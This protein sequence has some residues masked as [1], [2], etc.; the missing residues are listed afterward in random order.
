MKNLLLVFLFTSISQLVYAQTFS[1]KGQVKNQQN[2]VVSFATIAV[3]VSKDSSLAKADIADE[4]GSFKISNLKAGKYFI[5]ITAVSFNPFSSPAFEVVDKDLEFQPFTVLADTKQLNEVKVVAAKPLIEVQND[6]I[7]FNVEGSVN[8]TGLTALEL[9]QKSPGVQVD[10]DENI[11]V[12]GKSGVRIFIDGRPSPMSGK[13]LAST[14]KSMNSADIE[15]IEVITNPSAKYDAAGDLG[16]INIRLKKNKKI[17]TNGNVALGSNFGITPKFNGSL[18]LNHRDKK[19]NVYGNYS[20][21]QGAWHNRTLDDQILNN[22]AYN[23]TW[24]GIWRDT[25]HN[26]KIGMDYFIN[27]KHTIGISANGRASDH[28]GGGES[29]TLIGNRNLARPDSAILNSRTSNPEQNKNLNI[30]LNYRFAD[31]T[32]RELNIDADYG[33]FTSRGISYQPNTYEF[34]NSDRPSF[35]RNFV[36]KTPIDISIKS[37]KIDYEQPLKKGKLGYGIKLSDVKSDN[38]FDFF[39]VLNDIEVR[40]IERSNNFVYTERVYAA[41]ANYNV[42]LNKKWDLQLGLRAER[43]HSLGQLTS[44]KQNDLDK[45]DTT[46]INLF[47]SGAISYKLSENHNLNL[48]YSRRINRPSYQNL[49]P[50]EYRIDE[51]VYSKGNPFLRPEYANNFKLTHVYKGKLTTSLGYWRTRF[52]VVGLRMP[53]DESRTYFIAQNLD[54]TQ[55][56]SLDVSLA[57]DI[58]KWWNIYVNVSGYTNVFRGDLENG[59]KINNSTIA[60][61]ANAQT[62]FKLKN[63][64]TIELSGWYNSPYRRIDYNTAMGT[65]DAGVQKKFWKDN[66]TLKV[67]FT[68][69]L[70]TGRGGHYSE[71][72]GIATN[73]R[74]QWE[75]QQL[76]VNFTY[77]FGSNEIKGARNRSSGSEDE[78]SRIKGG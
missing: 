69:V 43:T 68:D 66:A 53:Y 3:H 23:K 22:I 55:G 42:S 48:N 31:T 19:I 27:S 36:T 74:F 75:S 47:P 24:N 52:P 60:A 35:S 63:N 59:L 2:E 34:P 9:L 45:V 6:K 65:M 33:I 21:N 76:R 18:N 20:Y 26:A 37:F 46:Y 8:A 1:V 28:N 40:D 73:L 30:N 7:V 50:F 61:N 16:I 62:T 67:S 10:R 41:Y 78:Q 57:T 54:Y 13:D 4:N 71:Y 39:N 12:K 58:T 77:R 38:T 70:H 29:Q 14:L 5:K 32:G 56:F 49:N 72:A 11:L 64:W 15:A 25:S 44:Y 51:L 17:G